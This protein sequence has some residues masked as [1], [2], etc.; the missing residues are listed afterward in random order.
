MKSFTKNLLVCALAL[1]IIASACGSAS[2]GEKRKVAFSIPSHFSTFWVACWKGFKDQADAQGWEAT[3]LDPNG[4]INLQI[5]QLNNQA[6]RGVD[7]VAIAPIDSEA[8]GPGINE[9]ARNGVPVFC[10]DRR[11]A[12]KVVS[13]LET[14]NVEVGRAMARQII[15]DYNGKKI[16]LLIVQGVLSDTPTLDR[17]AGL[18][19]IIT[20][21]PNITIIGEPS[22]GA[23]S[24]EAAMSTTKNYLESH[25]DLD[26]I[27]TCTDALVPGILAALK[28]GDKLHKVGEAGHV[29]LYSVDGA[30]ETLN[31]I[32]QGTVDSTYSQFPI[33]FGIDTIKTMDRFLKGEKVAHPVSSGMSASERRG[34][35][36]PTNLS[37]TSCSDFI[38][39]SRYSSSR[40]P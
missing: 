9:L 29:G 14:D 20:K 1:G 15:K 4:D 23:Y 39:S 13:T 7:A 18:K 2:A 5:T 17:T 28:E 32:V 36:H 22:A 6:T 35:L 33:T 30:G 19:E 40:R 3:L 21:D 16:D 12:G 24:N 26:V 31:F 37:F 27:F 34:Y 38:L 10:I 25:P 8:V 11:G